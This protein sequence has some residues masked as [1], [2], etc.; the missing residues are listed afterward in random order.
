M[1]PQP[2]TSQKQWIPK[3]SKGMSPQFPQKHMNPQLKSTMLNQLHWLPEAVISPAKRLL[4]PVWTFKS[5]QYNIR[6][7]SS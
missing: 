2:H 7:I 6:I 4:N 5:I 1:N 3:S